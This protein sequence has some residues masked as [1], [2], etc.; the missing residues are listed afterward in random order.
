[1]KKLILIFAI[2]LLNFVT[3]LSQTQTQSILCGGVERWSVN[4]LTD[5]DVNTINFIPAVKD[6]HL[7]IPISSQTSSSDFQFQ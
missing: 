4:V 3:G 7:Q 6:F 5:A 2:W 1:M